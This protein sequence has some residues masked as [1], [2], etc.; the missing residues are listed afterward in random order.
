MGAPPRWRQ[1]QR[2]RLD[3]SAAAACERAPVGG[4]GGQRPHLH[5]EAAVG[6]GAQHSGCPD[7][8][9]D[10]RVGR[11]GVAWLGT[12]R[13]VDGS[14][15][16]VQRHLAV[17]RGALGRAGAAL[18][19]RVLAVGVILARLRDTKLQPQRLGCRSAP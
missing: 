6:E 19:C 4:G 15:L 2:Q 16:A 1:R 14:R 13:F 18:L 9:E 5:E 12:G 10:L 11:L 8:L 7:V 17:S 3:G